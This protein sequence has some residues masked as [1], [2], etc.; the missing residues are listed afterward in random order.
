M[1]GLDALDPREIGLGPRFRK[2][3]DE[4]RDAVL[5]RRARDLGQ[6]VQA[7]GHA[8]KGEQARRAMIVQRPLAQRIARE[9]DPASRAIPDGKGEI[10]DHAVEAAHIPAFE[11]RQQD[12]R[13]AQRASGRQAQRGDELVAI[14]Q[15]DIGHQDDVARQANKRLP[16][17]DI[18]G[19]QPEQRPADG[20]E[21]FVPLTHRVGSVNFLGRE[22][23][24]AGRRRIGAAVEAP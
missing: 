23:A 17:V 10:A 13:V 19:Q 1:T 6:H 12:R 3:D 9:N 14:V 16:V 21:T 15:T 22:H 4:F 20:D 24:G 11:G 2:Q 7:L 8:G 5:V 18:L